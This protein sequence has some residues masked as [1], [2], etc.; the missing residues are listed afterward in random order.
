MATAEDYVVASVRMPWRPNAESGERARESLGR[1]P[2][3]VR[4][5]SETELIV[6]LVEIEDAFRVW[7]FSRQP[8]FLFF[9][10]SPSSVFVFVFF[11]NLKTKQK[12]AQFDR[13]ENGGVSHLPVFLYLWR[14][15]VCVCVCVC[16]CVRGW[17]GR[18]KGARGVAFEC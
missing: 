17:R 2:A 11:V 10:F 14:H 5:L 6:N 9:L 7:C 3:G 13:R 8:L 4:P 15:F 12:F 18:G 1:I 16:V